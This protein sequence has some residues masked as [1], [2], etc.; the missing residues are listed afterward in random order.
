MSERLDADIC[1]IGA[2][3]GGLSVAAGAAQLGQRTVLIERG[4]M[5]GDCLNYGCVPSKS[6]IAAAERA[7]VFCSSGA[8][9]VEP[10]E[11]KV[12]MKAVREHVRSVIAAIAPHD[13]VERFEGLGVRVI[14][15]HGRFAGVDEVEA[16]DVRIRARRFVI[17]TGSS[18]AIPPV[19]GLVDIDIL[20]N[21]TIFELDELP[22]HLLVLGAGPIG[23][24]LAQAFCR[25]GSKVTAVD[26]GPMLARDD[27]DL[28]K[29]VRESLVRDGVTIRDSVKI[30]RVEPGPAIVIEGAAGEEE[31]IAGSHLL[32]ATG[33]TPNIA[34]LGLDL[35]G[36]E[37][38]RRGITVDA[39]LR[40]TNRRIFA[41]GDVTGRYPF[42]H[43]AGHHA[44][45]VIRNALFRMPAK[46]KEDVVPWVTYTDPELAQVGLSKA[47]AEA[48]GVDHE[49]VESHYAENDRARAERATE[50]R[51]RLVVTRKGRVLGA[52]IVGRQAGELVLPWSLAIQKGMKLS[53]V[54]SA[55]VPY[56]TLSEI[57]KRAAGS[58]YTPKLF[59][60]R[61]RCIVRWLGKLG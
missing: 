47:E 27:E 4:R 52:T 34:D 12:D 22:D 50:G 1:I 38:D 11:P 44:G 55:I 42:T 35:A 41:I 53:D 32:V 19:P 26:I 43:M 33:R 2:G 30:L 31:R 18:P 25:L 16:G 5:G 8:F 57:G 39:R 56:P 48:R 20:T 61:T 10:V 21:E 15:A 46:V 7:H 3:S 54:A 40:T 6:L 37:H 29:T 24:E 14:Q 49:I 17:A 36:I 23:C 58:F 59:S 13:S 45:I 28:R 9:G 51:I 60:E